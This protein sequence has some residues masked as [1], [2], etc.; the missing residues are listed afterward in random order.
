MTEIKTEETPD[1]LAPLRHLGLIRVSGP[2]AES[3]LQGQ[4]TC[5]VKSLSEELSLPAAYCSPKG[6]AIA[7]FQVIK[8][9]NKTFLLI[10]AKDLTEKV[11]KRLKMFVMR[12]QVEIDDLTSA[13]FIGGLTIKSDS[14]LARDLNLN[15]PT[16]A[17]NVVINSSEIKLKLPGKSTRFII[18]RKNRGP[19]NNEERGE[20]AISEWLLSDINS[21]LPLVTAAVSEEYIPQMFNLDLLNGISFKK[22]CYTGQEIIARMHYLGKLKQRTFLTST[23][24]RILPELGTPVYDDNQKVGSVLMVARDTADKTMLKLLIVMQLNHIKGN[25]HL[26][27]RPNSALTFEDL[28]YTFERE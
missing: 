20:A 8:E 9:N 3:F 19:S 4:L 2:E 22:G 21:G 23:K 14:Q 13:C 27:N 7:S 16:E 11:T 17:N 26:K 25:I 10:L 15:F 12:A 24:S 6:R 5:N 1:N 18:I 28:P